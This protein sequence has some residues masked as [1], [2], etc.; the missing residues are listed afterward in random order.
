MRKN[1]LQLARTGQGNARAG[2]AYLVGDGPMGG[3]LGAA[4]AKLLL[5]PPLA[6]MVAMPLTHVCLVSILNYKLSHM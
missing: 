3:L 5:G 1:L 4:P 2:M 6:P